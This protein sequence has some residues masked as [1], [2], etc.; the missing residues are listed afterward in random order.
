MIHLIDTFNNCLISKHRTLK[1]A[2]KA[3][4][5][6]LKKVKQANGRNSYLT[7]GFKLNGKFIDGDLIIETKMELDKEECL[8]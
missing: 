6:H 5:N 2:V 7:Y 1:A 4:R 3:E 8:Y